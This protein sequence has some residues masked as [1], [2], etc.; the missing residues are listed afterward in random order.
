MLA[1]RTSTLTGATQIDEG[2]KS[3]ERETL[4]K[5]REIAGF[6]GAT[7]HVDRQAKTVVAT[8]YWDSM[9]ALKASEKAADELRRT[10]AEKAGVTATPTV[11][12]WEC[13]VVTEIR[14]PAHA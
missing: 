13:P 11:Q 9:E 2:I 8:T 10:A 3:F 7:M 4:P 1:A 6:A 14:V 12:R 5:L